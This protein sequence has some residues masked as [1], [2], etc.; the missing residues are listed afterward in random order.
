M[1][2]L[3]LCDT[4]DLMHLVTRVNDCPHC[5]QQPGH[6]PYAPQHAHPH[7]HM[8]HAHQRSSGRGGGGS[9]S[10][11]SGSSHKGRHTNDAGH[12]RRYH[13]Y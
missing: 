8:S 6:Q 12:G 5:R 10:K 13:P 11:S 3:V 4:L 7:P 1:Y 2:I 9:G